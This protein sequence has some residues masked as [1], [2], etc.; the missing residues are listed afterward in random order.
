MNFDNP[1]TYNEKLQW[2]K[3]Y[4]KN[5]N[6]T[7]LVDKHSVREYVEKKCGSDIL[8]PLLGVWEKFEDI[9]IEDL[10]DQFVL[11]CSHD[12]GGLVICHDKKE[13]D[14]LQSKKKIKKS[15]KKNY[16][17][18]SR[19]WPYKNVPPRIIG[20]KYIGNKNQLPIDYTPNYR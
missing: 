14:L 2:M 1:Q 17:F 12:S 5:P 20:E 7:I 11:K 15:L 8:I 6:Y 9:K 19:E 13:L 16:Y 10:P 3:L 18:N 4:N